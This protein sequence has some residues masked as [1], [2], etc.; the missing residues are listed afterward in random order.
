MEQYKMMDWR[1]NKR[2]MNMLTQYS[3]I[4]I[5]K[6]VTGILPIGKNME[7]R[8]EWTQDYCPRCKAC[9]ET[10]EHIVRCEETTSMELFKDNLQTFKEMMEKLETPT[11]L[12]IHVI[13]RITAW[14]LDIQWIPFDEKPILV[15]IYQQQ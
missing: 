6:F 12:I 5:S 8:N 7:R 2:A 13:T 11:N 10:K 9:E 3:T 4:W 15:P 1:A 14:K